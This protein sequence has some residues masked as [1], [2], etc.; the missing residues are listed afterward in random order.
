MA[1]G[2]TFQEE[3]M[4]WCKNMRHEVTWHLRGRKVCVVRMLSERERK[5]ARCKE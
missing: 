1:E 2:S 5:S 3:G 4:E